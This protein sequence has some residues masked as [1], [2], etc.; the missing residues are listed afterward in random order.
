MTI[1]KYQNTTAKTLIASLMWLPLVVIILSCCPSHSYSQK[2]IDFDKASSIYENGYVDQPYLVV[3]NDGSWLCTFTT[4]NK[5]EG[6]SGQHIVSTKSNDHG[7][8]WSDPVDI[9]PADGPAASWAMP[10]KTPYGRVYVFY[11]YNGDEV[12]TLN[13]KA[14]RN[15]MLGWYCYKYTDDGGESWSKRFRLPMRKTTADLNNDWQG[16]VQIFWGIGKPIKYGKYMTFAFTKIGKYML[17]NGEGWFYQSD[18]IREEKNPEKINW[19]LLPDGMSG[20]R[21]PLFGSVQ[22]EFNLVHINADTLYA[23]Y[24]TDL[25]FIA[26]TMSFDNGHSWTL[27][28]KARNIHGK[29]LKN[30]R[31]CPRIWQVKKGHYLIWYHNHSGTGF[32]NRNPGWVSGGKWIDGKMLW[33]D[34]IPL[35]YRKDTS[36]ASG[37]L[38]YPDLI[39]QNHKYWLTVTN[40]EHGRIMR[41]PSSKLRKLWKQVK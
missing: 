41:I 5:Q 13:N 28:D 25:G 12:T 38:S 4:S 1:N 27:P 18:N 11:S 6:S 15:D 34:P 24:R 26:E 39:M 19:S 29:P 14:I 7:K 23:V 8:T 32:A 20:V 22:E 35:V 33:S 3:L 10:Y 30:P 17:D 21:N 16:D 31:A 37:R 2:A 36:Y 9:E 40:K